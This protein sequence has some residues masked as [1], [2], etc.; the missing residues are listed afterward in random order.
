M[1]LCCPRCGEMIPTQIGP[2]FVC[3]R[4]GGWVVC[5]AVG[6]AYHLS[7]ASAPAAPQAQQAQELVRQA[8]AVS[9]P[10]ARHRM[11]LEA[12]TL[13]P[14]ELAVQ[15]A[16]LRLGR[17]HERDPRCLDY[18]CIK[19]YLLHVFEAPEEETPAQR[20]VM[21][22]ELTGDPRLQRCLALAPDP[23]AFLRDELLWIC[24]EYIRLFLKGS[25][26]HMKRFM[27]FQLM[28]ADRALA[29][30]G[31]VMLI[32][33]ERAALPSPFDR[34]LPQC[35]LEAYRLEVGNDAALLARKKEM[36]P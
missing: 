10:V 9:D 32:N 2:A 26:R 27:G 25:S 19:C 18:H 23:D 33:M 22:D 13:C 8:E 29:P 31:A 7:P 5:E 6:K 34:L 30:V 36:T 3:S 14:E 17:L 1:E 15:R 21:L 35:F 24:Q 16:L 4:C 28:P 11:L 12:E 20:R